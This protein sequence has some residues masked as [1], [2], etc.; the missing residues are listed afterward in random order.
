MAGWPGGPLPAAVA[1]TRGQ[2]A[3]HASGR[4]VGHPSLREAWMG[5]GWGMVLE[6]PSP[7]LS[8]RPSPAS[9]RGVGHFALRKSSMSWGRGGVGHAGLR[10][11]ATKPS[12]SPH[13]RAQRASRQTRRCPTPLPLAGEGQRQSPPPGGRRAGRGPPAPRPYPISTGSCRPCT[14]PRPGRGC[15]WPGRRSRPSGW[16]RT[17]AGAAAP[18][19]R[20]GAWAAP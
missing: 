15:T 20:R 9:G 3:P 18:P 5:E 7:R 10:E 14:A 13:P 11:S 2:L 12:T 8:P 17:C 16:P 19:S 6:A 1:A 4:G